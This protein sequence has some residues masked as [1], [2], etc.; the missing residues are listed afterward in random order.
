MTQ[1]E[2]FTA[3]INGETTTEVVDMARAM[4]AKLD[5]KNAKRSS[6]PSKTAIAN[7][8]IKTQILEFLVGKLPVLTTDIATALEIS[9]SKA[10]ALCR[11]LA[12][13]GKITVFDVKVPKK[14]TQKAYQLADGE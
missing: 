14:G 9:T 2:F 4:L 8:P 7:E 12:Q 6:Q 5:E 13:D 10:S 1:R 3:V 11:Q